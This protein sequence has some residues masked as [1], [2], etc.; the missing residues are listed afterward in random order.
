MILEVLFSGALILFFGYCILN[1]SATLP[2]DVAG[3]ISAKQ[4]SI[5]I[6]L[7]IILF[8]IINIINVIRKTPREQRSFAY[9]FK[10]FS[11]EKILKSKLMWGVISMILYAALVDVLGFLIATF[12][13]CAAFCMI[14]GENK[15]WKAAVFSLAITLILYFIFYK[16]MGIIL[17]R[18]SADLFGGF[19]R[20]FSRSIEKFV[21]NL[22]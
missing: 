8:L 17:P 6:L 21:R 1:A 9:N 19:F 4:W 12:I 16:G 3:E 15:L 18:G 2:A 5:A 13:F 10:D 7:L 11:F 14:L 22:F 20:D